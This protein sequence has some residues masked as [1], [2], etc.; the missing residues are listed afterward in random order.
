MVLV[1]YCFFHSHI[2]SRFYLLFFCLKFSY[3]TEGL[4]SALLKLLQQARSMVMQPGCKITLY[5]VASNKT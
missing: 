4:V 3:A 1:A 2:F 5:L